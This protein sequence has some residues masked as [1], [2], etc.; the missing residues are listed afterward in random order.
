[1][2]ENSMKIQNLKIAQNLI[3]EEKACRLKKKNQKKTNK[4]KIK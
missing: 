3:K 1:M 2:K 4:H